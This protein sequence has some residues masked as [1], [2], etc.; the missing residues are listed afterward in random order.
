MSEAYAQRDDAPVIL[1][2][3]SKKA[4][5]TAH[6]ILDVPAAETGTTIDLQYF[7]PER[8]HMARARAEQIRFVDPNGAVFLYSTT[9]AATQSPGKSAGL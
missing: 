3:P 6:V 7:S 8:A 2:F 9:P 4:K 1:P 5:P